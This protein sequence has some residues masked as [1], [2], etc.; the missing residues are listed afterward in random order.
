MGKTG[1]IHHTFNTLQNNKS[2]TCIYTDIY[3]T[4]NLQEFT[5]QLASSILKAFP[6]NQTIGKRF[7]KFVRGLSPSINFDPLMGAPEISF[8]YVEPKQYEHALKGL[9]EFLD[10]QNKHILIAID[11]FQQ[12]AQYPEKM[13]R[14]YYALLSSP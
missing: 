8:K 10:Q 1:L 6:S 14:H 9:F 7:M 3:A 2:W 12:V 5:N 13:L 4:Q 11:E